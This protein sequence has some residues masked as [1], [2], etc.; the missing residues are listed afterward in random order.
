MRPLSRGAAIFAIVLAAR[1]ARAEM[2]AG[3][4]LGWVED[5]H[6]APL[7][8]AVISLFGK[9]IG[10]AGLVTLSDSAGRFFVP[11]LPAGPYTLRVRR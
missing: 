11:A 8:G 10:G 1:S 9:G 2:P 7:S 4:L 5:A 3:G 6:G